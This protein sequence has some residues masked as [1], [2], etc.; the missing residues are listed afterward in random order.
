[1]DGIT[2]TTDIQLRTAQVKI[3]L[4]KFWVLPG[5]SLKIGNRFLKLALIEERQPEVQSGL[6]LW[7]GT[8]CGAGAKK[9]KINRETASFF[10]TG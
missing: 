5:R 10:A 9:G 1:L 7:K 6:S 4:G 2:P 8:T 3:G